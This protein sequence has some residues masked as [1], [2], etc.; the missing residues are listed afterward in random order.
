[1]R[2]PT[3]L[4]EVLL[5]ERALRR[6]PT[7]PVDFY[8]RYMPPLVK[9]LEQDMGCVGDP[10]YDAAID[11]LLPYLS[12]PERYDPKR[13]R[14]CTYLTRAA[15]YGAFD[16]QRSAASQARSE[17]EHAIRVELRADSPKETLER[18]VEAGLIM[19]RLVKRLEDARDQEALWLILMGERS[20][21]ALAKVLGLSSLPQDELRREVKRHRDR[22]M[23][24]LERFV[25]EEPHDES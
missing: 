14:L 10:A 7:V 9:I 15:K 1:M 13:G 18:K 8:E 24:V 19:K 23:K 2:F 17:Q 20:T 5:H 16:R 21:E 6:D 4:E 12:E 11:A 25:K 3:L 22:L